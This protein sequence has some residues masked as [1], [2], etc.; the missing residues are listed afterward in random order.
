MRDHKHRFNTE[1]E[2]YEHFVSFGDIC[3]INYADGSEIG[4]KL[5]PKKDVQVGYKTVDGLLRAADSNYKDMRV[6]ISED[7]KV[8]KESP[9]PS[10]T[11]DCDSHSKKEEKKQK[12]DGSSN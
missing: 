8:D 6:K 2:L 12:V 1:E 4:N 7:C 3:K 10:R 11:G 5:N 9:P